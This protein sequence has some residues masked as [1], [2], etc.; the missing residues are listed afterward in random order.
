[1]VPKGGKSVIPKT[2]REPDGDRESAYE[3]P[4]VRDDGVVYEWEPPGFREILKDLGLRML[5]VGIA[6]FAA[7]AGMEIAYFFT[8]RRFYTSEQKRRWGGRRD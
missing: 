8:K 5:E 1:M 4:A 6:A 3:P 2:S 7:E